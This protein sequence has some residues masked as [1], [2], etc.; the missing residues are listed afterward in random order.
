V[1]IC[2]VGWGAHVHLERW[3][4]YFANCG[5]DVTVLSYVDVGDDGPN[6]R[7]I[8]IGFEKQRRSLTRLRLRYLL[9]RLAPDIVHVH[10]AHFAHDVAEVWG[11]PLVVTAWG[12]DVY[13]S[14]AFSSEEMT[15]LRAGLAGADL[16]TCDSDDLAKEVA[17]LCP[18]VAGRVAVIQ[19]GI[20]TA[21]FRRTGD[22]NPFARKL[23]AVGRP[24][25]LSPR[26]FTALYNQETV[27]RS[28]RKVLNAVPNA[29]LILKRYGGD[30]SYAQRLVNLIRDLGLTDSVRVVDTVA[31]ELMPDLYSLATVSVSVPFSDATPMSLL[32]AMACGCVPVCSDLPSIREWIADG[33]NGYLVC[34][35]DEDLIA[36]RV[37]QLL[38][39]PSLARTMADKN[40]RL[41]EARA[42][43]E[44]H[45]GRMASFYAAL[46]ASRG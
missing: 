18:K 14:E 42:S 46:A 20:D 43:Q 26:N 19:W 17:A 11:G 24:V 22:N 45:M 29:L 7:Q 39:D 36:D 25:I 10:W 40:R 8:R 21:R 30:E 28:F 9:W 13:R 27:I 16:V 1:K 23:D 38:R 44:A 35:T 6:L 34:A 15:H 37:V 5:H 3:A 31:Y 41:V 2:Y 12:S 4:E 32:E 33:E